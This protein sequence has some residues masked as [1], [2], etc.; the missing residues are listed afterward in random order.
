MKDVGS[1]LRRIGRLMPI[2][3]LTAAERQLTFSWV[4]GSLLARSPSP[5]FA[6]GNRLT[7][8]LDRGSRRPLAA[9]GSR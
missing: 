4:L 1:H 8:A 3:Y 7:L 6:A 5:Y 9:P 2:G